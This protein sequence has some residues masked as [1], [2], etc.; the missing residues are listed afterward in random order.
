MSEVCR[1]SITKA[2]TNVPVSDPSL[3]QP[4]GIVVPHQLPSI[5]QIKVDLDMKEEAV[6]SFHHEGDMRLAETEQQLI[7][8]YH[9]YL[10][11]R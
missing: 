9:D 3:E 7:R 4:L 2:E 11:H 1:V 10:M 8:T 5:P 6:L